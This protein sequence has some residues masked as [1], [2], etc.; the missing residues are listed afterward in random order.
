MECFSTT[1]PFRSVLDIIKGKIS[2]G[3]QNFR[4]CIWSSTLCVINVAEEYLRV[5]ANSLAGSSE[6]RKEKY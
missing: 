6:T 4:W 3:W 1:S 2:P 5:E